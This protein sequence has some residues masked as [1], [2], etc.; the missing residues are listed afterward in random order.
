MKVPLSWLKEY[1]DCD[2]APEELGDKLTFSGIEV[3]GIEEVGADYVGMVVGEV[4]SIAPHPGADRLRLCRVNDGTQEVAVVCG[5]FNF[6]VGDK[7]PFAPA[8][9]KLPDGT[10]I[11]RAKIRGEESLGML[12]AEDELGIS[13]DHSG[14]MILPHDVAAGTPLSAV[15]GPPE[16]VLTLEITWNRPDCLSMIGIAREVAALCGGTLRL[17][18]VD[19]PE[20]D[21]SVEDYAGVAIEDPQGCP[22]Y[23]AR[24]LSKVV[25]GASPLW[26]QRRLTLAGV[27]PISN[28]VDITNYVLLECG[29]P[30]HAFDHSLLSEGQIVVRR[31]AE[32]ETMATLDDIERSLTPEMVVIADA[33]RPV[34]LAGIMGGAGTEIREDT[35]T[36]LLESA[37]FDPA[38]IHVMG[39]SAGGEA[40][41]EAGRQGQTEQVPTLVRSHG[42]RR[43][44]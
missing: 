18:S 2:V 42:R 11:K 39:N 26:M 23:T 5:A 33:E 19:Y 1:V 17:P 30:L 31:A 20:S 13:D 15:L 6:E 16:T 37:S 34:A 27:R 4:T 22:R 38:R 14:I 40:G 35:K 28:V 32:G 36:V 29:Q 10:K 25:L 24:A 12:C 43:Q 21:E 44:R 3:E 7:V 9:A 8:G 41:R